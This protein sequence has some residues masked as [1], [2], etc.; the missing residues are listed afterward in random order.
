MVGEILFGTAAILAASSPFVAVYCLRQFL[1]SKTQA[2]FVD[3]RMDDIE[4]RL[5]ER[6]AVLTKDVD[7]MKLG[8]IYKR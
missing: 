7:A 4:K 1:L 8:S 5:G 2:A 3:E 6:L